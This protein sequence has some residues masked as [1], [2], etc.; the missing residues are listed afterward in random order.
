MSNPTQLPG[1]LLPDQL[2]AD[3]VAAS[4]RALEAAYHHGDRE[5]A[6]ICM[7]AM[8]SLARLRCARRVQGSAAN[9]PAAPR[10]QVAT[11]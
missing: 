1:A 4:G 9:A 10:R 11:A 7:E 6:C 3:M 2:L 8:N 5:V